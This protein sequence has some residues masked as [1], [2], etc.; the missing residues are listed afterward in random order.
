M[1]VLFD[2]KTA[3][4]AAVLSRHQ[5]SRLFPLEH[6]DLLPE[7]EDFQGGVTP[8]PEEYPDCRQEGYDE[9]EH[10]LHLVTLVP[11]APSAVVASR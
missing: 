9:F 2:D 5:Q 8:T 3:R 7:G 10:A 11:K 4:N 1:A 6:S